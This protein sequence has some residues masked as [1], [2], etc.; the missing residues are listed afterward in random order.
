MNLFMTGGHRGA[1]AIMPRKRHKVAPGS[2]YCSLAFS[3]PITDAETIR[4]AARRRGSSVCSLLAAALAPFFV[5]LRPAEPP[6]R[7]TKKEGRRYCTVATAATAADADA[8]RAEAA[9]RGISVS[10]LLGDALEDYLAALVELKSGPPRDAPAPLRQ[11][12]PRPVLAPLRTAMPPHAVAGAVPVSLPRDPT[13]DLM[14]DPAP[15]RSALDQRRR[16][17]GSRIVPLRDA[18]MFEISGGTLRRSSLMQR[19]R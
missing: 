14:G 18:G 4:E 10:A 3:V 5:S 19:R 7:S 16:A 12:P 6:P 2:H 13:R 1:V 8:V 15:G 17:D 9:R 11:P